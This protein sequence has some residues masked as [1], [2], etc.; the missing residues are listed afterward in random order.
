MLG[1]FP[2]IHDDELLY[3]LFARY[4]KQSPHISMREALFDLF[5]D[6]RAILTPD[7]PSNLE[8]F[9]RKLRI[10]G[11]NNLEV[12]VSKHTPFYYFTNFLE[13][14]QK[15]VVFKEIKNTKTLNIQ[16][17]IG[18]VASTISEPSFFRF[19]PT[20][21]ESD[22]EKYGESFWRVSHQLPS[23]FVCP[24]HKIL[25]HNSTAYYRNK[26]A[27]LVIPDNSNCFST[28]D[29]K[30]I[31]ES[32]SSKEMD[33]LY[34]IAMESKMLLSKRFTFD[35]PS[36][37]RLY[38]EL[39]RA[40]GYASLNGRV[41]QFDLYHD[42]FSFYGEKFLRIMQSI[43]TSEEG[44]CWLRNITRKHRKSFHP[45][46]HILLLTFF[47]K[48]IC[49]IETKMEYEGP[50]GKGPFPCLN[51]AA[52]HFKKLVVI[53]LVVKRCTDTGRPLGVFTCSCGFQY[54]RLGPDL[55]ETDKF[56]FRFV[57]EYG[58]V[59]KQKVDECIESK[60]L[61]YRKTA[62]L[63]NVDVGTVIKYYNLEKR[64]KPERPIE[65]MTISTKEEYRNAW[66][67]AKEANPTLSKTELRKLVPKVYIWLYRNDRD[68]LDKNS[69]TSIKKKVISTRVDWI[70][71]DKELVKL[72]KDFLNSIDKKAKP[73]RITKR[74]IAVS[75][76]K[77][78]WIEKHLER[79]PLTRQ[80]IESIA[81][82]SLEYR[83]RLNV[84]KNLNK[85]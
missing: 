59:W 82:S 44:S 62:Q 76:G 48:Q 2:R 46:R 31:K 40:N 81:E 1:W 16:M 14:S 51:R 9:A 36:I 38:K 71:R 73:I 85:S 13:T 18:T 4:Y 74:Y 57:R 3:S 72:I 56:T 6:T 29:S 69:P 26:N 77:L 54:T 63:L 24:E 45:I 32:L 58:E 8:V 60:K 68:W 75:I 39:L 35:L 53:D 50:F 21:L 7:F 84:W 30:T 11:N 70:Q 83:E 42:F 34:K 33:L 15:E 65:P 79:L 19:C 20:C 78:S 66:Q 27:A 10:F 67:T 5:N 12:L 49:D 55:D 28:L 25:L 41:R 17:I 52:D 80:F 43:P 61:S 47:G 22:L 37:T 64:G 23:V